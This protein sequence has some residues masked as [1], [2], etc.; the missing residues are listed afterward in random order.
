[1]IAMYSDWVIFPERQSRTLTIYYAEELTLSSFN[2]EETR[3][4]SACDKKIPQS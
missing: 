1:M 3:L 4:R 2:G